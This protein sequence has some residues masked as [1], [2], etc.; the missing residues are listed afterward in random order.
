M[1]VAHI[2]LTVVESASATGR[3]LQT[4]PIPGGS[5]NAYDYVDQDPVNNYDLAGT[6]CFSCA[7][8]H[9]RHAAKIAGWAAGHGASKL[10]GAIAGTST[11]ELRPVWPFISSSMKVRNLGWLSGGIGAAVGEGVTDAFNSKLSISQRIWRIGVAAEVGTIS[12]A[13]TDFTTIATED[14]FIGF[15][16][17]AGVNVG[18]NWA[19]S[20]LLRNELGPGY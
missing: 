15:A 12:S 8:R 19:A 11:R 17:G 20:R 9:V 2:A 3:F 1:K 18:G 16:A 14:P 4:D 6:I 5:A 10:V 13:V 7:V